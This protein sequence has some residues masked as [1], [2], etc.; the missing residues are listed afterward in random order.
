MEIATS[1]T[2][3]NYIVSGIWKDDAG[4]DKVGAVMIQKEQIFTARDVRGSADFL[5]HY[6]REAE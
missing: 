2:R 4:K 3:S 5:R 6:Y 1:S